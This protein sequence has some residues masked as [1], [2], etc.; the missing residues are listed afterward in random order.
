MVL[1]CFQFLVKIG[2][3]MSFPGDSDIRA[4]KS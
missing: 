3:D 2:I 1:F 4:S